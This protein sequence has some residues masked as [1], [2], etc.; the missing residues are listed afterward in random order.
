MSWNNVEF[1]NR[2]EAVVADF[3]KLIKISHKSLHSGLISMFLGLFKCHGSPGDVWNIQGAYK[4]QYS[5]V[6]QNMWQSLASEG[7]VVQDRIPSFLET[8]DA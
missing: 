3:I 6:I 8:S 7:Y 5:I 4:I 1:W 2:A